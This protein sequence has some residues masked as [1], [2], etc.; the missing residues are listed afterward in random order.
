MMLKLL[1]FGY[2]KPELF[3]LVGNLF[4]T[5]DCE[6]ET[7]KDSGQAG[8]T[9]CSVMLAEFVFESFFDENNSTD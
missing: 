7:K 5:L 2:A 1:L 8:M 6:R 9:Y 4:Y 3:P